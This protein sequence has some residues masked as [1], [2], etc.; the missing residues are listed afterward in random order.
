MTDDHKS[1]LATGRSEGRAVRAYLEALDTSRPKRGRKRTG[2]SI[3]ARLDRIAEEL[4]TADPLKRLTLTQEQL[5]LTSELAA[6]EDT[7]DVAAL[8]TDFVR[9]ARTYAE[10]KGITYHAFRA[11]GVPAATLKKAG[12]PRSS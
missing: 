8:E 6:M 12:I 2:A 11:I 4:E 5:D 10:R 7:T 1:A 9:V 3:A